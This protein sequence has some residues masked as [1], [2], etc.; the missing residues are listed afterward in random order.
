MYMTGFTLFC[1]FLVVRCF[2]LVAGMTHAEDRVLELEAAKERVVATHAD[3][4]AA[5][6]AV[7][8]EKKQKA[9]LDNMSRQAQ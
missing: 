3:A 1:A 4:A 2:N 6:N 5:P 8:N 9:A 7:Q